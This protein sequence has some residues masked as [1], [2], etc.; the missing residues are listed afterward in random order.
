[1]K[2]PLLSSTAT[3]TLT[4]LASTLEIRLLGDVELVLLG[5]LGG[6]LGLLGFDRIA[7]LARPGDRFA[8]SLV[9]T[10]LRGQQQRQSQ[11]SGYRKQSKFSHRQNST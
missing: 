3:S 1:M 6:N 7:F 5:Q 8:N 2:W 10:V 11:Q 9:R 4:T